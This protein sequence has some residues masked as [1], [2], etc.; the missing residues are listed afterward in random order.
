MIA[1]RGCSRLFCSFALMQREPNGDY[2]YICYAC[3]RRFAR[4]YGYETPWQA[5]S[6]IRGLIKQGATSNLWRLPVGAW[7]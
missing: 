2:A 6:A 4:R 7:Q 1:C 3:R 5:E